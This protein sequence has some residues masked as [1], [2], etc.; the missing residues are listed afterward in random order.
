M[1]ASPL[2]TLALRFLACV[3]VTLLL[4]WCL[5][6]N[7]SCLYKPKTVLQTC[8]VS[9]CSAKVEVFKVVLDTLFAM[10]F[11]FNG[12]LNLTCQCLTSEIRNCHNG[13]HFVLRVGGW[14]RP[15][16]RAMV[17][18]PLRTPTGVGQDLCISKA[19][20]IPA[21]KKGFILLAAVVWNR[22]DMSCYRFCKVPNGV[23]LRIYV[24]VYVC[25]KNL[26]YIYIYI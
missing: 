4:G 3:L 15:S 18:P 7:C 6:S 5:G 24:Y 16:P 17:L 9:T 2:L 8:V 14:V 20:P 13:G 19:I 26:A 10:F 12:C 1:Y 22:S 21:W 23:R 11:N 25:R